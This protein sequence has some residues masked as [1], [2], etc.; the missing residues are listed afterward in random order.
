[1][2]RK[3]KKNTKTRTMKENDEGY[4]DYHNDA[5]YTTKDIADGV[6]RSAGDDAPTRLWSLT[7]MMKLMSELASELMMEELIFL[8]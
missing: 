1:M 5:I 6:G 8:H 7:K 3:E 4:N 2:R